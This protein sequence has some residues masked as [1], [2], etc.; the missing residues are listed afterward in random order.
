[1]RTLGVDLASQAEKTTTCV[2]AWADDHAVVTHLGL[3]ASD[4]Q[5]LQLA[6]ECDVVGIDAPF[7]WPKP[8]VELVTQSYPAADWS[9]MRR[10]ELCF[11][12]TDHRVTEILGRWPLSVS[13]DK[14]GMVA[15]RCSGLLQKLS[16][17]DRSGVGP[18]FE[19]YPS[20]ALASWGL[21]SRGYKGKS[22]A[23]LAPLVDEFLALARLGL[24]VQDRRLC[25]S[26]DH[27]FDALVSSIIARVAALGHTIA[28]SSTEARI[29]FT[30]GWIAVPLP[31]SLSL[32]IPS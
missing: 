32:L 23:S 9:P 22:L 18:V 24:S 10:D 3:N 29:A 11:R 7:G 16:V 14:L 17:D 1:M 31:G 12:T 6:H 5:I 15:M 28:P 21:Q 26:V 4:V 27:V 13:G 20:V 8:F 25:E 2:I 30:E 19:V